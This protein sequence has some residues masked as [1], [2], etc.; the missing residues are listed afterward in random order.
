MQPPVPEALE[1][2]EAED[3]D[4]DD[5]EF[6]DAFDDFDD[7]PRTEGGLVISLGE[8]LFTLGTSFYKEKSAR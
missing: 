3:S 5:W 4:L 1:E 6:A 2:E 8:G 7:F